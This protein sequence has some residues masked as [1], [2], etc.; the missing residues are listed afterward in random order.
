MPEE[1]VVALITVELQEPA[2]VVVVAQ[3]LRT[4]QELQELLTL[5]EVVEVLVILLIL[6]APA[7][8]ES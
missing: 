4:Q 8:Q 3:E 6:A 7:V 1:E 5:V 2:E